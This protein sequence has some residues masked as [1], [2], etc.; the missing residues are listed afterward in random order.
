[1]TQVNIG[2]QTSCPLCEA[3]WPKNI[4]KSFSRLAMECPGCYV[5]KHRRMT[6]AHTRSL[7]KQEA[8]SAAHAAEMAKLTPEERRAQA[9]QDIKDLWG[10]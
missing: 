8:A 4:R 6:R 7:K 10:D 9:D 2:K 5:E 1:M 3:E